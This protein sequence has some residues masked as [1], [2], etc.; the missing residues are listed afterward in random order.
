M[1][2][3]WPATSVLV[4]KTFCQQSTSGCTQM[5]NSHA[6]LPDELD[7]FYARFEAHNN[8]QQ[9]RVIEAGGTQDPPFTLSSA[10]VSKALRRTNPWKAVGPDNI[11]GRALRSCQSE[12]PDVFANI[13]NP[14]L[15]H[16]SVPTFFKTTTIVPLPK[17]STVTCLNDCLLHSLQLWWSALKD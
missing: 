3:G 10:E 5:F 12:L 6:A 14:S 2:W 17:N 7:V 13:F 16:A 8:K 1:L 9:W 11:L 4:L 15:R